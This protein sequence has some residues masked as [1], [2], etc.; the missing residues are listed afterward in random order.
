MQNESISD[1]EVDSIIFKVDWLISA[2][3]RATT[4]YGVGYQ[5]VELLQVA[6]RLLGELHQEPSFGYETLKV[7]TACKGRPKYEVPGEQ[8]ELFLEYGFSMKQMGEMIGISSKTVYRRLKE[9][10]LSIRANFTVIEDERLDSLIASI[11]NEF[12]N[13]GYK[14]MTGFLRAR[15][16]CLQQSRIR[17]AMRRTDPEGVLVR[18]LQLTTVARRRYNVRC[19]LQLWHLDVAL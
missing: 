12:P 10:G 17:E 14:R 4:V 8:L 13:C 5:A 11:L 6:R 19:P 1:D 15:G 9:L 16:L 7:F 3:Q 18:S 2:L